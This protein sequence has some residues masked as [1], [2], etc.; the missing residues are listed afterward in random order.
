MQAAPMVLKN[1]FM[2]IFRVCPDLYRLILFFI[3]RHIYIM[4]ALLRKVN[5]FIYI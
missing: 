2:N 5:F 4:R 1:L 3:Y